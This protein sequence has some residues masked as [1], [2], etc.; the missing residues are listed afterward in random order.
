MK[1]AIPGP[2]LLEALTEDKSLAKVYRSR[3]DDPIPKV[4]AKGWRVVGCTFIPGSIERGIPNAVELELAP[5]H[6]SV[7]W[8]PKSPGIV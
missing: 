5:A 1:I 8:P 6:E 2:M 4:L 3:M 7:F